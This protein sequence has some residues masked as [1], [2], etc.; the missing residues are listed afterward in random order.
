MP[1]IATEA[2]TQ[3]AWLATMTLTLLALIVHTIYLYCR[4]FQDKQWLLEYLAE[5]DRQADFW[6]SKVAI[7]PQLAAARLE[8][9]A[10]VR[11]DLQ[12]LLAQVENGRGLTHEQFVSAVLSIDKNLFAPW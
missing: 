7:E 2:S 6:T 12:A 1:K 5:A 10:A 9:V 3:A 4:R 8:H 11:S